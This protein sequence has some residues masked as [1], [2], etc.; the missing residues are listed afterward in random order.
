MTQGMTGGAWRLAFVHFPT[1]RGLPL[2]WQTL[3]IV[4]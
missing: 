4:D 2:K 3:F 1:R